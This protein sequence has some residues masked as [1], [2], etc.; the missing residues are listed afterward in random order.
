MCVAARPVLPASR[1]ATSCYDD[2]GRVAEAEELIERVPA[3][4]P[5]F[6]D[7]NVRHGCQMSG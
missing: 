6:E 1:G 5:E 3:S 7:D 4:G 2:Q